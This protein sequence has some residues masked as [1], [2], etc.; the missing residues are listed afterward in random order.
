MLFIFTEDEIVRKQT[1][2][3][4]LKNY[5]VGRKTKEFF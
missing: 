1:E 4:I 2:S 5:Y 3:E